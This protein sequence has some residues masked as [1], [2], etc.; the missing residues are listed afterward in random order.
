[1]NRRKPIATGVWQAQ[2]PGC[3]KVRS[4]PSAGCILMCAALLVG[5]LKMIV[6]SNQNAG[7]VVRVSTMSSEVSKTGLYYGLH[8]IEILLLVSATL[9]A[10]SNTRWKALRKGYRRSLGV[11]FA[12]AFLL[13][14]RGMTIQD[15]FSTKIIGAYG[16]LLGLLAFISITS[17]RRTDLVYLRR[18]FPFIAGPA[19]LAAWYSFYT[20]GP[21]G[22]SD[23]QS[24]SIFIWTMLFPALAILFD[25]RP[26]RWER[27]TAWG[28]ILTVTVIGVLSETRLPLILV[29]V[30][31]AAWLVVS[32]KRNSLSTLKVALTV[33]LVGA[34][35][36]LA[37]RS[38]AVARNEDYIGNLFGGLLNRISDDTRSGQLVAFFNDVKPQELIL[39]RGAFSTWT[40]SGIVWPGGVDFGYL[41][42]AFFG[43]LPLVAG[44]IGVHVL[45][46]MLQLRLGVRHPEFCY[47]IPP[48][49]FG[50]LMFSSVMPSLDVGYYVVL[51]CL[52]RCADSSKMKST[53]LSLTSHDH[54]QSS[55]SMRRIA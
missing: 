42:L 31:M 54:S 9:F 20:V 24:I 29:S 32:Y 28:A 27:A 38:V 35:I 39:G 36:V 6:F 43:G 1:M 12:S 45:P 51:I 10:I 41:T 44:F 23:F 15:V 16:P 50:L 3:S 26:P 37:L 49:I 4:G 53:R 21:S 22:R 40:W 13:T 5:T 14:L 19:T 30:S 8:T 18:V 47:A 34:C 2:T 25:L 52:G 48:L 17:T 11:C 33:A 55:Q 46:A 7:P